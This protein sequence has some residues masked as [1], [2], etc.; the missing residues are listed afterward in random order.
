VNRGS[1][2]KN[3]IFSNSL[4]T[5]SE[6]P[7]LLKSI[8]IRFMYVFVEKN[9]QNLPAGLLVAIWSVVIH[10]S[11]GNFKEKE[12]VLMHDWM[13]H[14]HSASAPL[15]VCGMKM[16]HIHWWRMPLLLGPNY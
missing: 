4:W 1:I 14:V 7:N 3:I 13:M 6:Y 9:D 10:H 15:D 16:A 5:N 2:R 11:Y 8:S 12:I